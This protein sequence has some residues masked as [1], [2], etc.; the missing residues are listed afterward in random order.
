MDEVAKFKKMQAL[1]RDR[2]AII[3]ALCESDDVD[4]SPDG[5]FLKQVICFGGSKHAFEGERI[6]TTFRIN[7]CGY[8]C[9]KTQVAGK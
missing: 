6:Q 7:F 5:S 2:Q 3:S 8:K 4:I 9:S 1:T